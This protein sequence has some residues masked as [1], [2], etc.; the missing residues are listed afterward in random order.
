MNS[1][2]R[3]MTLITP[4]FMGGA[5]QSAEWRSA[6]LKGLLRFWW[7]VVYGKR[8]SYDWKT[9]REKEGELWGQAWLEF[10]DRQGG[11]HKWFWQARLRVSLLPVPDFR[12]WKGSL[13]HL[14]PAD[15]VPHPWVAPRGSMQPAPGGGAFV[16]PLLYLGYGPVTV[17]GL[18]HPPALAPGQSARLV[19]AWRGVLPDADR[20]DLET[21]LT[22]LRLFGCLGA[23]S[24]NGWGSLA[25]S[26]PGDRRLTYQGL[27]EE[28]HDFGKKFSRPL[29]ECLQSHWPH[30]LA[31]GN[32][33]SGIWVSRES[34]DTWA[35]A[36]RAVAELKIG[37]FTGL[38]RIEALPSIQANRDG[39]GPAGQ[40]RYPEEA[41]I[42]TRHVLNYPV[43]HHGVAGWV[44]VGKAGAIRDRHGNLRQ[45]ERLP[46]QLRF[47][48]HEIEEGGR[49]RFLPVA[50]HLGHAVPHELA[51]K[52]P[53]QEKE[54]LRDS[55]LAVWLKVHQLL[56]QR[57]SPLE[58]VPGATGNRKA[59]VQQ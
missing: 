56:E 17:G 18:S 49:T 4:G 44:Q 39:K 32:G 35:A 7:R 13:K 10:R 16:D 25:V 29:R 58:G 31:R 15:A 6:S 28:L 24:R 1:V 20:E 47:K 19:I 42:T 2:E 59:Q 23:R 50:F 51:R 21:T 43:T 22:A 40:E 55:E 9:I 46:N 53:P 12:A 37:I 5:G 8:V 30:A 11:S 54:K 3:I 45:S 48:V 14:G 27:V 57:W 36:L 26:S 41:G 52:L 34:F 38:D 33:S